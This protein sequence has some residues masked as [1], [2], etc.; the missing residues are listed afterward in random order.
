MN[1]VK[2]SLALCNFKVS[3]I[4]YSYQ[5]EVFV[6]TFYYR[7]CKV[8]VKLFSRSIEHESENCNTWA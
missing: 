8:F 5:F 4:L 2:S 6:L 3:N 7:D 1:F